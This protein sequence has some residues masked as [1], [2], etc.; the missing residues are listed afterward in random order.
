LL[1]KAFTNGE[2]CGNSL[3]ELVI[4]NVPRITKVAT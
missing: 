1:K 4:I 3:C 2:F